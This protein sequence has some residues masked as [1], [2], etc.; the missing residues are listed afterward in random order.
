MPQKLMIIRLCDSGGQVAPLQ[1]ITQVRFR[2]H[3]SQ[4]HSKIAYLEKIDIIRSAVIEKNK[5]R[6]V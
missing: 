4:E 6:D 2:I 3:I 5:R 1:H